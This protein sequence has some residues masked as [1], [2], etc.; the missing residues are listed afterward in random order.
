MKKSPLS[1]AVLVVLALPLGASQPLESLKV[2]SLADS[3]ISLAALRE[4]SPAFVPGVTAARPAP[5]LGQQRW[6]G[7]VSLEGHDFASVGV[8]WIRLTVSG[9]M[10]VVDENGTI[11][12]KNV[13]VAYAGLFQVGERY[14][15]GYA[16]IEAPVTLRVDGRV[17]AE[18]VLRGAVKMQG[19]IS[20]GLA[21]IR[22][23]GQVSG[24]VTLPRQ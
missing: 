17:A 15:F 2:S 6:V 8:N 24:L 11:V 14:I 19:F 16:Q 21:R 9:K 3:A 20:A 10:N 1:L 4:G 13:P 5:A 7:Y 23:N 22:G 18:G 12:L